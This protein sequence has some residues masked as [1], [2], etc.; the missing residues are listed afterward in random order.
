MTDET[1]PKPNIIRRGDERVQCRS[2]G[3]I[4]IDGESH[5]VQ[6]LDVSS[7]GCKFRIPGLA[8]A[9]F[10]YP[11]P[12]EFEMTL[13]GVGLAGAIIWV[14]SGMYGCRFYEHI[15]L[16]DVANILAGGFRMRI[17]PTAQENAPLGEDESPDMGG[18]Q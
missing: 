5:L 12:S 3:E 9:D 7:G 8:D 13:E 18:D 16:D 15:M 1:S 6:M 10:P 2:S 4:R 14:V 11:I 17:L